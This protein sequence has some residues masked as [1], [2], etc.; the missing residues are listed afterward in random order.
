[1]AMTKCKECKK[2]VSTSAESCPHCG[3][4]EPGFSITAF[5]TY[6]DKS[7]SS[8]NNNQDKSSYSIKEYVIAVII[9]IGIVWAI[10]ENNKQ[11]AIKTEQQ[12]IKAEQIAVKK[13]ASEKLAAEKQVAEKIAADIA[14]RKDIQC[15]GDKYLLDAQLN[16]YEYV[17]KQAKYSYEWTNGFLDRKFGYFRWQNKDKG[18]IT[19]FGD[20]IKFQNGYG[21][22]ENVIYECDLDPET[23]A[24]LDVRLRSGRL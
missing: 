3:I 2:D 15:W 4:S 11:Q 18:H 5:K 23:G 20:K 14:C 17:E 7:D 10:M 1:M 9:L 16:C 24:V 13:V 8:I 6:K 21:A 19:Y 12:A 22:W